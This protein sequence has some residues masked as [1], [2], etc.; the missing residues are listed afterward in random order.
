MK[1]IAVGPVA[2][3]SETLDR[4]LN[5]FAV[6]VRVHKLVPDDSLDFGV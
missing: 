4:V 2:L 1:L 5:L 3:H 6:K